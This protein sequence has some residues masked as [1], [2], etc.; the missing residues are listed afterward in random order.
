MPGILLF[1]E[2]NGVSFNPDGGSG[3]GLRMS[4]S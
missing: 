2:N 4:P 1:T 3:R